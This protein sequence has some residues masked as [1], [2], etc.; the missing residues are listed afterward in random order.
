M[1]LKKI[2]SDAY[3]EVNRSNNW[4]S[5]PQSIRNMIA[6]FHYRDLDWKAVLRYFIRQSI[7][8]N[9]RST[10]KKIN[11]KYPGIH[12][13]KQ[14]RRVAN[15]AISVDQSGSVSDDMLSQF[16]AQMIKL[17]KEVEFT[18]IPFDSSVD[19]DGIYVWKKNKSLNF[20]RIRS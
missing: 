5:L 18:V 4:G 17:S 7:K 19:E 3:K 15:I 14:Y 9:K 16:V 8:A 11:R 1:V 20:V 6:Q 13:G 2:I 10:P 12:P